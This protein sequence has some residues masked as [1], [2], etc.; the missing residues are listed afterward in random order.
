MRVR[1]VYLVAA[2]AAVLVSTT[3][4][5]GAAR[6]VLI[7]GRGWGHGLGMSQYGAFGRALSGASAQKI[8][9]HYYSNSTVERQRMPDN[10]RVGLLQFRSSVGIDP[11]RGG[12]GR[13]R[14]VFKVKGRNGIVA[15][16]GS[17]ASFRVL[18]SIGG[19]SRLIKNGT[20]VRSGGSTVFG[21]SRRPL[22]AVYS[23]FGSR[24]RVESKSYDVD[25]GKIEFISFASGS[26]ASGRCLSVVLS[27]GMQRYLYGL[28]EMPSSWPLAALQSQAMAGRTYAFEKIRRI[29]Q[30]RFGCD[31]A[32]FDST[33][34]QA[35]TGDAHRINSGPFWPR[36]KRAVAS[37]DGEVIVHRGNPIQALY[38]SS[39]GGHTEN[40]HNV[41]GG[42]QIPYLRGVPDGKDFAEGANPNFRWRVSMAY[43]TFSSRLNAA[44]GT[45]T[46][47]RFRL[48]RPFGVSGRVTIVKSRRRGGARVVGSRGDVRVSGLS[49]R[50]ALGLRDTWFRVEVR[51]TAATTQGSQATGRVGSFDDA[52]VLAARDDVTTVR[53]PRVSACGAVLGS[54]VRDRT[55]RWRLEGGTI[56]EGP[57]G[58]E[59]HC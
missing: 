20:L 59:V 43:Q 31:C 1:A 11:K 33:L 37:T 46:L 18:P 10:V 58:V 5:A 21:S 38:S 53:E 39:S 8:V 24:V 15:E 27:I 56:V 26:C 52:I 48:K 25:D 4:P 45:G 42:T 34:D 9:T 28:A 7:K 30:H 32:V 44:Y 50:S 40:N 23:R 19:G 47:R 55:T 22:T 57:R 6:Q 51:R 54:S 36:W 29:G 13:G 3:I 49:L 41:F 16:G 35:F 17:T 2:V 14:I 12:R